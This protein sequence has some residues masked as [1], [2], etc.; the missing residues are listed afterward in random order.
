[1]AGPAFFEDP[2][3]QS[4]AKGKVA[5]EVAWMRAIPQQSDIPSAVADAKATGAS[6]I[7]LYAASND[8]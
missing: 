4:S 8:A 2:S 6:G 5:G 3:S 1:M 7:K